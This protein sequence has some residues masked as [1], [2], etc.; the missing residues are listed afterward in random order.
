MEEMSDDIS[1]YSKA[2]STLKLTAELLHEFRYR[3][4]G[5]APCLEAGHKIA[6]L[7]DDICDHTY[8]EAFEMHPGSFANIGRVIAINYLVSTIM[9]VIGGILVFAAFF[10]LSLSLV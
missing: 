1:K 6:Q 7:L 3:P 2:E 5:S 10:I 4:A 9:L 8:E